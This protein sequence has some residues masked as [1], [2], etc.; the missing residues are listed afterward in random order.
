M[1]SNSPSKAKRYRKNF[2]YI[3]EDNF[4]LADEALSLLI[5]LKFF[6]EININYYEMLA[7]ERDPN[8]FHHTKKY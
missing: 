2:Q 6:Q 7:C 4:T 3:E 5:E 1:T 8:I